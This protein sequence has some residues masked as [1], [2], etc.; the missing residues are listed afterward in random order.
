MTIRII[1]DSI[2]REALQKIA[3]ERFGDLIKAAIDI[4]QEILALGP[5]MHTDAE[6]ELMEKEASQHADVW[7]I[8]LYPAKIGEDFLE[9]DSM[10]N[11]KPAFGNRTR[12]IDDEKTRTRIKEII[13]R[14][15]T[16]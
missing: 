11:L 10:I 7:G 13:E 14:L 16:N 2:S 1:K 5:E 9:F 6:T 12:G 4:R 15:V 8:N 3:D